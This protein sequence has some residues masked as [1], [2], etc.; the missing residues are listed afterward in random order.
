MLIKMEKRNGGRG[1]GDEEGTRDAKIGMSDGKWGM[2]KGAAG[3]EPNY[4][5]KA[6]LD[7][8]QEAGENLREG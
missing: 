7:K 5:E 2:K 8:R 1:T 6:S 4:A 3:K